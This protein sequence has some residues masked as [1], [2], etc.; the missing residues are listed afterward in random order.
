MQHL[1]VCRSHAN[2]ELFVCNLDNRDSFFRTN[3]LR[4]DDIYDAAVTIAKSLGSCVDKSKYD[5]GQ[6][7]NDQPASDV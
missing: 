2:Q 6:H 7:N 5:D 4:C 1:H 3:G